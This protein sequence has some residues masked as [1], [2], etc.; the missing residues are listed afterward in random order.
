MID[1]DFSIEFC[2]PDD[3]TD[4][5]KLD[6]NIS[7]TSISR[8]WLKSL[9]FD[10]I[11]NRISE[12][13]R[14]YN[15][16][17]NGWT[18]ERFA[19]E[20][21]NCIET[22]NKEHPGLINFIIEGD[23]TQEQHNVLHTY[24]EKYRGP[25]LK[26]HPFFR[27]GSRD[28]RNAMENLNLLIHRQESFNRDTISNSR[29]RRIVVEFTNSA[30]YNLLKEDYV[31]CNYHKKFGEICLKY[32]E[33]GKPLYDVFKDQDEDVG[34][35]NIKP[36]YY[37]NSDFCINLPE[38]D[39]SDQ[40]INQWNAEFKQWYY[41]NSNWLKSLGLDDSDPAVLAGQITVAHIN[42]SLDRFEI[43]KSLEPRQHI[44]NI[45]VYW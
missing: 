30:R 10:S 21:N 41:N 36:Q 14:F 11:E 18:T 44:K 16:Q 1:S 19:N 32:C 12:L 8:K 27:H 13:K 20:I 15:F 31:D 9:Y 22:C 40:K 43:I 45:E 5:F 3:F 28:Y 39:P 25:I 24:F 17:T 7:N 6:F 4:T 33:V 2:S 34:D 37:Y 29:N 35:D 38:K 42:T 23:I 26:P